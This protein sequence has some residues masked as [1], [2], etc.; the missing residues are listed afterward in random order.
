MTPVFS[1]DD[2]GFMRQA[3]SLAQ[4]AADSGE[5]PVGAVVVNAGEIVGRGWNRPVASHDPTAH[6]EVMAIREA[7]ERLGNYRL[8]GCT[9]YVTLEPC[10]MCAAAIHLARLARVVYAATEPKTGAHVSQ[11]QL[12]KEG[13]FHHRLAIEMGLMAEESTVLLTS[14]FAQRREQQ[15][16]RKG[17]GMRMVV[18]LAEQTLR[19]L[20]SRNGNLLAIYPVSTAAK[21]AGEQMGSYQTPRGFHRIRAKIGAGQPENTVFVARRPT[22]EVWTPGLSEQ[23]PGRDWILTRIL[24]LCGCE[25]GRNRWGNVDTMRRYI[26]IHGTPD[27]TDISQPGSHGCI[28][29]RNSD[30]IELF[31]RVPAGISVEIA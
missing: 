25:P 4:R 1:A 15:K 26:Y 9:L 11:M 16:A 22:G 17:Q 28:R 21:G 5:V 31:E 12:F 19:L 8:A 23:F 2:Y 7:G 3:L 6:A 14:F 20:D 18:S 27:T 24:W 13:L 30:L 10:V 29:M